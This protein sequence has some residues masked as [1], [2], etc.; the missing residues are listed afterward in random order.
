MSLNIKMN[1]NL[2]M[3][4]DMDTDMTMA[5]GMDIAIESDNSNGYEKNSPLLDH[6]RW[7][8]MQTMQVAPSSECELLK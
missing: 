4:T 1:S 5:M 3:G 2:N 7:T 8:L 6:G